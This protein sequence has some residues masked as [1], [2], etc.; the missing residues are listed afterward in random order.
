MGKFFHYVDD[1]EEE[2]EAF[3]KKYRCEDAIE[4]PRRIPIREIATKFMNLDIVESEYLSPDDS[5]QGA[6]AFSR[7]IIE[8]YDWSAQE[9]TGYEVSMPTV[10]VDADIVN[11]GRI[12]NTLTHECYHWWRHR[13]YFNYKRTH[14]N[15][16]EFGI[17]CNRNAPRDIAPRTQWTDVERMEYQARTIAPKI[18]MPRT[19]TKKKIEA[20]YEELSSDRKNRKFFTESVIERLSQFFAV[21]RQSAAI[22]MTELGYDEASRFTNPDNSDERTNGIKSRSGSRSTRHQQPIKIEEAFKLYLSNESLRELIDTGAFCFA[23]GYF[24]LRDAQYVQDNGT[25]RHLTDYARAHLAECS[26]DF[27]VRL[28]AEQVLIHDASSHMMFR[29]DTQYTK[30]ASVDANTQNTEIYN[31]A[32]DFEKQFQ[33]AKAV[34]KTATELLWSYMHEEHWTLY[35]FQ[36]RTNL[37]AMTYTRIQKPDYKFTIRPLVAMGVG[38]RLDLH[39][40]EEV[41]TLAGLAFKEGDHEQQAYKYLFTG[42][43]GKSIDDCNE[44]LRQ[45]GVRELGS[46]ERK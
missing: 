30:E 38:L 16:T 17:R 28:V 9:Y 34:H 4:N 44:F 19:A 6:I 40:M 31:K 35:K 15:S 36:D 12:N 13:S 2:A 21:S 26:I 20:L 7:G 23:D 32:K 43:Y 27:S 8:V 3:L 41:L 29:A 10:F 42:L 37:D 11:E 18:L 33:R 45:V 22:R 25:A 5:V 1:F 14:E 39:A 46:H 24:V